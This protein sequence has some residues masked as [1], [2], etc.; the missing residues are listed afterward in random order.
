M[1]VQNNFTIDFM[2][3]GGPHSIHE[4]LTDDKSSVTFYFILF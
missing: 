1:T 2:H 3:F 4:I